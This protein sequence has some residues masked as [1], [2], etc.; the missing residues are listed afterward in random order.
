[1]LR[2]E[3]P[4]FIEVMMHVLHEVCLHVIFTTGNMKERQEPFMEQQVKIAKQILTKLGEWRREG[5]ST[6]MMMMMMML[7]YVAWCLLSYSLYLPTYLPI[8]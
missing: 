6:T 3:R 2:C 5:G 1:M 7:L 8:N 4:S